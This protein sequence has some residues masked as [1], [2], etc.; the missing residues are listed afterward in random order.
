M[1]RPRK[2]ATAGIVAYCNGVLRSSFQISFN[3]LGDDGFLAV[4][5][6]SIVALLV[7]VVN[8]DLRM[9]H[10][11][12]IGCLVV[13]VVVVANLDIR[14]GFTSNFCCLDVA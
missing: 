4:A 13:V 3:D 5:A 14:L 10:G 9:Q 12:F 6:D 7:L 1:Y 2:A 11:P 8:V